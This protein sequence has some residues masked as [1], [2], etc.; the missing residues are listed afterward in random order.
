VVVAGLWST[1][2]LIY[3]LVKGIGV[4]QSATELLAT[5]GLVWLGNNLSFALLFWLIDGGGSIARMRR[6]VPATSRSHSS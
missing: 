1:A 6:V 3:D 4:S 2:L 5:G